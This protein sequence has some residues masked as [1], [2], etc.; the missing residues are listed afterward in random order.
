MIF[1]TV[2][3]IHA[4]GSP[5]FLETFILCKGA[6]WLAL[7]V[8]AHALIERGKEKVLQDGLVISRG[9]GRKVFENLL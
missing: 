1:V 6:K 2:E 8:L 9:P 7:G 5:V 4:V 3:G